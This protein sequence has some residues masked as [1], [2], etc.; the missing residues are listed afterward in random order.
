MKNR[1]SGFSLVE[2]LVVLAIIVVMGGVVSFSYW[3]VLHSRRVAGGA[4][5]V[6]SALSS[7]RQAA[8]TMRESRALELDLL[9]D[10]FQILREVYRY[11]RATGK[12]TSEWESSGGA[13]QILASV[14]V[15]DICFSSDDVPQDMDQWLAIVQRQAKVRFVFNRRGALSEVSYQVSKDQWQTVESKN[16]IIHVYSLGRD[17]SDKVH[18][19]QIFLAG[20]AYP[21]RDPKNTR[22]DVLNQADLRTKLRGLPVDSRERRKCYSVKLYGATGR[23]IVYDYG[24]GYPWPSSMMY[25]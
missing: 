21:Y 16:P 18:G 4:E 20:R 22:N 25:E 1:Q 17:G 14:D 12:E 19:S 15:T 24:I 2:M 3:N 10:S 23:S 7:S 13:E 5:A 11:D 6:W 9:E 8:I